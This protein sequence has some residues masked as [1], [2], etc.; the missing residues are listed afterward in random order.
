MATPIEA[1]QKQQERLGF[2]VKTVAE[3][4]ATQPRWSAAFDIA[5]ADQDGLLN[6]SECEKAIG[7]AAGVGGDYPRFKLEEMLNSAESDAEGLI[8]FRLFHKLT[9][10]IKAFMADNPGWQ[11]EQEKVNKEELRRKKEEEKAYRLANP[12]LFDLLGLQKREEG[13]EALGASSGARQVSQ[14]GGAAAL[15]RQTNDNK[16]K[17][18]STRSAAHSPIPNELATDLPYVT[19]PIAGSPVFA[20]RFSADGQRIAA[21]FVDGALRV[22]NCRDALNRRLQG[23]EVKQQPLHMCTGPEGPAMTNLRWFP[24][25]TKSMIISVDASGQLVI[26]DLPRAMDSGLPP[27]VLSKVKASERDLNAVCLSTDASRVLVAGKEK[28]LKVFDIQEGLQAGGASLTHVLGESLGDE[29]SRAHTGA[30]MSICPSPR[31]GEVFWSGGVDGKL[32]LWDLRAGASPVHKLYGPE[33]WGDAIDIDKDGNSLITGSHRSATPIQIWDIRATQNPR[34]ELD[35]STM[36]TD[37]LPV[38]GYEFLGNATPQPKT[39]T[40]TMVYSLA[41]DWSSKVIVA[42][43]EKDPIA[44][45]FDRSNDPTLP[46]KVVGSIF[47]GDKAFYSA[48]IT[49]KGDCA[50]FGSTDGSILVADL[51]GKC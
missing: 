47:N 49:S 24:G 15:A 41:W 3:L 21:G 43:G 51:K 44:R 7:K 32:F 23:F 31:N 33:I 18:S 29:E 10:E 50:A 39:P 1:Y 8:D 25:K 28:V 9:V 30:I 4:R 2:S 20:L 45:I 11:T 37:E 42:A 46:L 27:T 17:E 14:L 38:H 26:W 35:I 6:Q 34:E 13:E 5:D 40:T 12:D 22:Y 36:Y 19:L 48:A 16:L